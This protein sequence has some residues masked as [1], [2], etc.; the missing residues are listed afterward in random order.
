M[1]ILLSLM[2]IVHVAMV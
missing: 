1:S 2:L